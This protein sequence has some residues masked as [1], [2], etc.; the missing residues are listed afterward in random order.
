[1]RELSP[2]LMERM[3]TILNRVVDARMKGDGRPGG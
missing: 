1:M 3:G 2:E